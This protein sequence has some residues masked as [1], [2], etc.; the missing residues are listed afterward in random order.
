[1][2]GKKP[3][4]VNSGNKTVQP[5]L[6]GKAT[7]YVADLKGVFNICHKCSKKTGRGIVYEDQNQLY[8]SRRCV[9]AF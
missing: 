2:A 3:A 1:M 9:T 4:K 8:C 6:P 7:Y 5:T